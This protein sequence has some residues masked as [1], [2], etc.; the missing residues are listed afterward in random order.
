MIQGRKLLQ[1]EQEI[2]TL[3]EI[4]ERGNKLTY[5]YAK[6]L[7]AFLSVFL[8]LPLYNPLMD[9][10]LPLN[11]SRPRQHI[12]RVNYVL[13]DE[14]EYFYTVYVHLTLITIIAVSIIIAVDSL[15]ITIIHHA[16]GLFT[17]CG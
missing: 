5:L 6:T 14:F 4:I 8:C 15:Y 1:L 12:Y 2:D 3:N 16:C 9:I 11:E 13:F 7:M 10:I 17:V